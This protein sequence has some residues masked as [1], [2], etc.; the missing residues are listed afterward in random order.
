MGIGTVD[1]LADSLSRLLAPPSLSTSI[2][3]GPPPALSSHAGEAESSTPLVPL[4]TLCGRVCLP[5]LS[6][7]HVNKG[8]PVWNAQ[9]QYTVY[10]FAVETTILLET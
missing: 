5:L 8:L 10:T 1:S 6:R 4:S 9:V 3:F 2:T 7:V